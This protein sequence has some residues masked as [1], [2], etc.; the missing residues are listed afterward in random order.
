[1]TIGYQF[2]LYAQFIY[3]NQLRFYN[4]Q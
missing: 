3:G 1:L 4:I 2:P